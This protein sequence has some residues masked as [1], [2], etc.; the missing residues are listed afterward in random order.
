MSIESEG[1]NARI[2]LHSSQLSEKHKNKD[3]QT[4]TRTSKAYNRK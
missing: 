2:P 4:K 1:A 3:R